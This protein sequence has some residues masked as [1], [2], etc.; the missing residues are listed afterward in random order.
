MNRRRVLGVGAA[1]VLAGLGAVGVVSWANTTKS[2]AEDSRPRP[3]SSS[4]TS[5]CPRAPMLPPSWPLPTRAPCSR[6]ASPLVRSP[7][8]LRSAPRWPPPTCT[9]A[10]SWSRIA[11]LPRWTVASLPTRCRSR[12]RSTA[13]RA[14]GG[15]LKAGDTVGVYLSF[16]PFDTNTPEADT[17]TPAK[18]PNTTHLEFQQV[19]V[20]NVQATSDPVS[21]PRTRTAGPAGVVDQLHRDAGAHAGAE[22][23]LRVRH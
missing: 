21:Q 12:P 3:P 14:V 10:S 20:T 5:T 8:R 16:E 19:L 6:R 15:T 9:R 18:T 13:E 1:V 17:A 11:S 22:R 2:S 4:W 7:A 23:A